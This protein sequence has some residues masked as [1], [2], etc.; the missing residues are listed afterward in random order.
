MKLATSSPAP[1]TQSGRIYALE[2]A[3][4]ADE[5]ARKLHGERL[6]KIETMV[7]EIHGVLVNV[8][9]FKWVLDGAFKYIGQIGA[10]SAV[11]YGGYRFFTGH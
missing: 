10:A 3:R 2:Q 5:A 11:L 8:R 4:E 6:D 9:G 1:T 7:K